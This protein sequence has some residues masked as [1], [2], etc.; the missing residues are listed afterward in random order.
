[1]VFEKQEKQGDKREP[2]MFRTSW[3]AV[4]WP[5]SWCEQRR[6][7]P[8][9]WDGRWQ[10]PVAVGG[11]SWGRTLLWWKNV[12]FLE[13]LT[14]GCLLKGAPQSKA[15]MPAFQAEAAEVGQLLLL[16]GSSWKPSVIGGYF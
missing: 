1:M 16:A 2:K 3:V 6:A 10:L 14:P 7:L 15:P 5:W 9:G 11:K 4:G 8:L 13:F 12:L